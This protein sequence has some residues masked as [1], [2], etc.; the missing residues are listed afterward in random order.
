MW[1]I[2]LVPQALPCDWS[3]LHPS[4]Q[5][6]CR[7]V[8]LCTITAICEWIGPAYSANL[9][10]RA[11]NA[12]KER[13]LYFTHQ[14]RVSANYHCHVY[15]LWYD[16]N[17]CDTSSHVHMENKASHLARNCLQSWRKKKNLKVH[18]RHLHVWRQ[19]GV[20]SRFPLLTSLDW[21]ECTVYLV[22]LLNQVCCV[23]LHS[24]TLLWMSLCIPKTS[25]G[26]DKAIIFYCWNIFSKW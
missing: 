4:N 21:T 22:V 16:I 3:Q 23:V 25:L 11:F 10:T 26:F 13:W 19:N 18:L 24:I 2:T 20:K 12:L 5:L 17:M 1:C 9:L 7:V 15:S 6:C 8:W 14:W